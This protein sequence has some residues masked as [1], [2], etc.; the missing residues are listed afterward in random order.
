MWKRVYPYGYMDY[1]EKFNRTSLPEKK[2]F[3]SHLNMEVVTDADYV[4][5]QSGT[6]LLA[7]VFETFRNM[8]F[9]IY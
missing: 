1:W 9:K 5:V 7:D 8:C 2:D 3:Y 6:L 4:Y